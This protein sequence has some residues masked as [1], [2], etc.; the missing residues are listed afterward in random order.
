MKYV[1]TNDPS[2]V[3]WGWAIL[4]I[5]G[6]VVDCG[7]IKTTPSPKKLNVRKGDDRIRRIKEL[8]LELMR[9]MDKYQPSLILSEQ[10]HGS[11]SASAALMIGITAGV[12]QTISDTYHTPI[13]WYMESEAKKAVSG[14]RSVG[15]DEMVVII[16]G[17]YAASF[18]QNWWKQTKW[19]NQ[20][21]ADAL[22]VYYAAVNQSELMKM[23]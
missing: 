7:A 16:Q 18:Q 1:L 8:N 12:M 22:A 10:P 6:V 5:D 11:Q 20:A 19:E 3:A 14:K 4:N 9:I 17:R 15:K 21:I 2:M 23:L 13:E